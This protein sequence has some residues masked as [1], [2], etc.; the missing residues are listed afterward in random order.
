[1]RRDKDKRKREVCKNINPNI[2]KEQQKKQKNMPQRPQS[3]I[4][5]VSG[6]EIREHIKNDTDYLFKKKKREPK[7]GLIFSLCVFLILST[8]IITAKFMGIPLIGY[9]STAYN[10]VFH[11]FDK[12]KRN[13]N[14]FFT[15]SVPHGN[16]EAEAKKFLFDDYQDYLQ[17]SNIQT[18]INLLRSKPLSQQISAVNGLINQ[19]AKVKRISEY[20]KD[21]AILKY[22][23]LRELGVASRDI[24]I[25]VGYTSSNLKRTFV[26]IWVDGVEPYLAILSSDGTAIQTEN[27]MKSEFLPT[28]SINEEGM[29]T[30][31]ADKSHTEWAK[32]FFPEAHRE[33]VK[34]LEKRGLNPEQTNLIFVY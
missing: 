12:S 4:E 21:A 10:K 14:I 5:D 9:F 28:F 27:S 7:Y 31:V 34:N 25:L 24:R 30:H 22:L 23:I 2:N 16:S 19:N 11:I 18:Q 13:W 26:A 8:A 1:M 17:S 33:S 15:I 29:R 20:H 3:S 6:I 32:K